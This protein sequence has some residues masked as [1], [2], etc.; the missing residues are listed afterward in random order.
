MASRI[1]S[2]KYEVIESSMVFMD[3]PL[4]EFRINLVIDNEVIG[5]V[6]ICFYNA[7]EETS[8]SFSVRVEGDEL[9]V[10]CVNFNGV[11]GTGTT[12]PANIG[13]YQGKKIM[14]HL[15]SY[16]LGNENVRKVEYTIF[17]EL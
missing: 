2:G 4:S 5:M 6:R 17:R 10:E 15:W 3:D 8:S 12:V 1:E 7:S 11:L 13:M 9:K 16:L 14:L